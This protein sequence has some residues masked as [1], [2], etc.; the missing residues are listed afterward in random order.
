LGAAYFPDDDGVL[1]VEERDNA[2][3]TLDAFE[4]LYLAFTYGAPRDW[5]LRR[6]ELI[7]I[8]FEALRVRDLGELTFDEMLDSL[9][10]A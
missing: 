4:D 6:R 2:Y 1:I 5:Y 10:E 7:G 8:L 3:V 9:I